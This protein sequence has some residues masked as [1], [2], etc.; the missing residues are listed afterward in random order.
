MSE[1]WIHGWSRERSSTT[2]RSAIGRNVVYI[3]YPVL[4]YF[5][6]WL[7]NVFRRRPIR[8]HVLYASLTQLSRR[9]WPLVTSYVTVKRV[10]RTVDQ[11]GNLSIARRTREA[12]PAFFMRS[13]CIFNKSLVIYDNDRVQWLLSFWKTSLIASRS[14]MKQYLYSVSDLPKLRPWADEKQVSLYMAIQ[15]LKHCIQRLI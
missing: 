13:K 3:L 9:P 6:T 5:L 10:T 14:P 11:W 8:S 15:F 2:L 1:S 4:H 12:V 7:L